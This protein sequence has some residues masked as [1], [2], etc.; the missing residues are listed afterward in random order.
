MLD[1]PQLRFLQVQLK[2]ALPYV[3]AALLILSGCTQSTSPE[4]TSTAPPLS[5]T[6]DT[7]ADDTVAAEASAATGFLVP[8]E[9]READAAISEITIAFGGDVMFDTYIYYWMS[10]MG[11]SYPWDDVAHLFR[12]SDIG[13][14]NFESSSSLRGE[15]TKPPGYG[16]RSPPYTLQSLPDAGINYVSLG[17][18]HVLDFGYDAFADTVQNLNHYEMLH[19]GAGSDLAAA[20]APAIIEVQGLRVGFLSYTAILPGTSWKATDSRPGVA[21]LYDEGDVLLALENIT[22]SKKECDILIVMPHW[23]VE[24]ADHPTSA[25]RSL[26][27][28]L[29]DAG[30]DLIVGGHPHVLQGVEFYQDKPIFYSL[31]NFIFLKMDDDAGKTAVFAITIDRSGFRSC[32]LYPVFIDNCKANL[33]PEDS[34]MYTQI[35]ERF[36]TLSQALGTAWEGASFTFPD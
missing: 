25:Q 16:F 17:N 33:L 29:I 7:E 5:I 12:S 15:T 10:S 18:N 30:A 1:M 6:D 11:I 4:K 32:T 13:V 36:A 31:G 24:Y 34:L 22:R 8:D 14:V 19:S 35:L 28:R 3:L 21:A 26:A 23:G 2:T 9:L 27:Y 20:T